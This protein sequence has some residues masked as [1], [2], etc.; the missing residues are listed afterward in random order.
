MRRQVGKLATEF[1]DAALLGSPKKGISESGL[2]ARP[3]WGSVNSSLWGMS[4]RAF[5]ERT[6]QRGFPDVS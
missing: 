2:P 6:P 1:S 4:E 5:G 3:K